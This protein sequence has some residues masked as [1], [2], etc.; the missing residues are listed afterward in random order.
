MTYKDKN[1]DRVLSLT[2]S[3]LNVATLLTAL[4]MPLILAVRS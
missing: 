4:D 3:V 1:T 2:S